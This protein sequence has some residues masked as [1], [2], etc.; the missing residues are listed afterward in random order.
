MTHNISIY[1]N[2]NYLIKT[3]LSIENISDDIDLILL[4]DLN[5]FERTGEDMSIYLKNT[6]TDII[7]ID[8]HQNPKIKTNFSLIDSNSSSTGILIYNLIKL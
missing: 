5:D 3:N 1:Y 6:Q 8:H 7:V 2:I 4:L